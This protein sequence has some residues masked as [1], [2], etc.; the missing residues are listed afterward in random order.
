MAEALCGNSGSVLARHTQDS[1]LHPLGCKLSK[2]RD[3]FCSWCM[4]AWVGRRWIHECV[5][6]CHWLTSWEN[7]DANWFLVQLWKVRGSHLNAAMFV[8]LCVLSGDST[9]C[10]NCFACHHSP[11][12]LIVSL[13]ICFCRVIPF[14]FSSQ[15]CFCLS[16]WSHRISTGRIYNK[17]FASE[18]LIFITAK[19]P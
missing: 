14:I 12:T 8:L 3:D 5:R 9:P 1:R 10:F 18:P 16:P 11:L 19:P 6:S 2:D 7:W 13:Q 17:V 4:F 15:T